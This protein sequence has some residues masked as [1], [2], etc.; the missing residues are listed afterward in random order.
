MEV[1]TTPAE[2]NIFGK[3]QFKKVEIQIAGYSERTQ[4]KSHN[5]Q[6]LLIINHITNMWRKSAIVGKKIYPGINLTLEKKNWHFTSPISL[7]E[8][9]IQ[10]IEDSHV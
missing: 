5:P 3:F 10:Y 1:Y 2:N 9:L 7:H 8:L 6:K 4:V